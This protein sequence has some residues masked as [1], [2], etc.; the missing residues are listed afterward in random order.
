MDGRA[1]NTILALIDYQITTTMSLKDICQQAH[2]KFKE[3]IWMPNRHKKDKYGRRMPMWRTKSIYEHLTKHTMS[4]RVQMML[5][6]RE[7]RRERELCTKMQWKI[8]ADPEGNQ[9]I[10]LNKPVWQQKKD[11]IAREWQLAKLDVTKLNSYR[12]DRHI[13]LSSQSL[14]VNVAKK[15][16]KVETRR[17]KPG[18]DSNVSAIDDASEEEERDEEVDEEERLLNNRC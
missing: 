6:L 5:Q 18:E 12:A 1:F 7:L 14:L 4:P 16:R 11:I 2:T 17:A 8:Q 9:D 13:D 10:L 15:L 3:E